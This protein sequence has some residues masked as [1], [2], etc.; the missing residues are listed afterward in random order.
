MSLTKGNTDFFQRD[1]GTTGVMARG[2]LDMMRGAYFTSAEK[3]TAADWF[4]KRYPIISLAF[5]WEVEVFI[6]FGWFTKTYLLE[7]FNWQIKDWNYG[8]RATKNALRPVRTLLDALSPA[9]VSSHPRWFH[10]EAAIKENRQRERAPLWWEAS[11]GGQNKP[12]TAVFSG[13][14]ITPW[15]FGLSRGE[16]SPEGWTMAFSGPSKPPLPVRLGTEV[17]GVAPLYAGFTFFWLFPSKKKAETYKRKI[18]EI[19]KDNTRGTRS[20]QVRLHRVGTPFY[21]NTDIGFFRRAHLPPDNLDRWLQDRK[22]ETKTMPRKKQRPS[23]DLRGKQRGLFTVGHDIMTNR[24]ITKKERQDLLKVWGKYIK[25]KAIAEH[26]PLYD[27]AAGTPFVIELSQEYPQGLHG[28]TLLRPIDIV[29]L[30]RILSLAAKEKLISQSL[31]QSFRVGEVRGKLYSGGGVVPGSTRI[32]RSKRKLPL[33][34]GWNAILDDATAKKMKD[35]KQKETKRKQTSPKRKSTMPKKKKL[36]MTEVTRE[37]K[38]YHKSRAKKRWWTL[39]KKFGMKNARMVVHASHKIDADAQYGTK[40][41]KSGKKK[42]PEHMTKT[43]R[44]KAEG[45]YVFPKRKSYPIGDLFHARMAVLRAQWPFNL[46]NAGKVLRAVVR[47]WPQYN[48]STYW[49]KEAKEAKNKRSIKTY[50]KTIKQR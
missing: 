28:T 49:N 41:P 13:I 21:G 42:V 8:D 37:A 14:S 4:S 30:L 38:K 12:P 36:T 17:G 33:K 23:R 1:I 43:A 46:K 39:L 35:M 10:S 40:V 44:K 20:P 11:G 50:A 29:E 18:E 48:W 45:T 5:P 24:K 32:R 27:G 19:A 7:D 34:V 25:G 3:K 6:P 47:R 9:G 31:Y 2:F 15:G 26:I 16:V 22:K